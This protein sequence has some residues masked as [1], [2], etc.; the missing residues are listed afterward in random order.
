MLHL[1]LMKKRRSWVRCCVSLKARHYQP[2]SGVNK[3]ATSSWCIEISMWASTER[4]KI[5]YILDQV[6]FTCL[7][8]LDMDLDPE[9]SQ[10]H[11]H[12]INGLLIWIPN[13]FRV[14]YS[15]FILLYEENTILTSVVDSYFLI[16]D[17]D[18]TLNQYTEL[19]PVTVLSGPNKLSRP[20]SSKTTAIFE[21][22]DLPWSPI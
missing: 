12:F 18:Q 21:V 16:T 10:Y 2:P 4:S 19:D 3:A 13:W 15:V 5:L 22:C 11:I 14:F 20:H 1:V 6:S 8:G 9:W 7:Y 17:P